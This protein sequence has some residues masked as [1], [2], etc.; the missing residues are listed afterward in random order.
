[1]N[2]GVA[3][4]ARIARQPTALEANP[5]PRL[6]EFQR[7]LESRGFSVQRVADMSGWLAYHGLFVASISAALYHC[8]TDP[9]LLAVDREELRRMCRAITA[10]FRA[11]RTQ[12]VSGLPRNLAVLRSRALLPV[13]VRYWARSVRSPMGEL[14]FAS[15]ARH[16]EPEMRSL[17]CDVLGVAVRDGQPAS[18][19]QLYRQMSRCR[20]HRSAQSKIRPRDARR[21]PVLHLLPRAI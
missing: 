21:N 14:A 4:Y 20:G 3:E 12:G 5:E 11:L 6:S 19:P 1:M 17:A 13:A 10:G 8:Q 9:P 18:L 15:H 2:S 7:A 16:A